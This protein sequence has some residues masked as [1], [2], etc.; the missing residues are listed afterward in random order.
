MS[1]YTFLLM[2]YEVIVGLE[3]IRQY[4]FPQIDQ[5]CATFCQYLPAMVL[6]MISFIFP[7]IGC[8]LGVQE[9][10]SYSHFS[11]NLTTT[12]G[13]LCAE[14]LQL[15]EGLLTSWIRFQFLI[16]QSFATGRL[17]RRV[18]E[19]LYGV[20]SWVVKD[21]PNRLG[22]EYCRYTKGPSPERSN[23]C[24]FCLEEITAEQKSIE[25]IQCHTYF[26]EECLTLWASSLKDGGADC[27]LCRGPLKA[28][29]EVVRV[30]EDH[31]HDYRPSIIALTG[32]RSAFLAAVVVLACML[33]RVT[34]GPF[35]STQSAPAKLYGLLLYHAT[36]WSVRTLITLTKYTCADYYRTMNSATPP[37]RVTIMRTCMAYF[38]M[39]AMEAALICWMCSS[40]LGL[41]FSYRQPVVA[42]AWRGY[43]DGCAYLF[44]VRA[45]EPAPGR[46][47]ELEVLVE[48]VVGFGQRW[49]YRLVVW[50]W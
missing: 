6:N 20:A 18:T 21:S 27:A 11:K 14:I 15:L 41:S 34:F 48:K 26:H 37:T 2:M 28:G 10:S 1:I 46:L 30:G 25:H 49:A 32:K 9:P 43:W 4:L 33:W 5:P 47:N 38:L 50:L 42:A 16:L 39:S 12:C 29:A 23:E 7:T 8:W 13:P 3:Q 19:A 24:C 22:A 40:L 36:V 31:D 35:E 45:I 17:S 44:E